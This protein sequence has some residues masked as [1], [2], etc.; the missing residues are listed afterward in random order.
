MEHLIGK[1]FTGMVMSFPT[2][3]ERFRQWQIRV[4]Y[5]NLEHQTVV[6]EVRTMR[7]AFY[8]HQIMTCEEVEGR[9]HRAKAAGV[10]R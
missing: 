2:S 7:G 9:L 8:D 6:V 10:G 1:T 3:W 4:I 5:E